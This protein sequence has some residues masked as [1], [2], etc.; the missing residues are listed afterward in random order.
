MAIQT[1]SVRFIDGQSENGVQNL[2]LPETT[3]IRQVLEMNRVNLDKMSV[4]VKVD[5]VRVAYDLDDELT[6][7]AQITVTPEQIKGA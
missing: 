4:T 6:D 7:G 1:V 3:T 5:G 2:T